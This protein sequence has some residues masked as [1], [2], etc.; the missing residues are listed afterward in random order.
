MECTLGKYLRKLAGRTDMGDALKRLDN[1]TH[2][3]ARI[4]IAQDLKATYTVDDRVKVV[5]DRVLDVDDR[6]A[7]IDNRVEGINA[8]VT[9]VGDE[10]KAVS[11]K[12]EV[13]TGG[14]Q[15]ISSWS[16]DIDHF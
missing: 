6:V 11:D 8:R 3:E 4:A 12:V 10:V 13:V 15:T 7:S 2:E 5:V 9:N 14:T 1:L 16:S